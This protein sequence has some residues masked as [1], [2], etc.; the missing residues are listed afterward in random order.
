MV[1]RRSLIAT[2]PRA[3]AARSC[4][5]RRPRDGMAHDRARIFAERLADR[6]RERLVAEPFGNLAI[7]HRRAGRD[8][9][10]DRVDRRLKSGRSR[11]SI[12]TSLKSR[13]SPRNNATI[14]SIARCTSAGGAASFAAD[15]AATA[16]ARVALSSAS[17]NST[18]AI[19]AHSRRSRR[20]R[21]RCQT[22]VKSYCIMQRR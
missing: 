4:H 22:C 8:R 13:F 2:P 10:R 18:P 17:G 6:A 9:T 7:R 11:S 1:S 16:R 3:E 12:A 21:S 5:S 14:P 15:S 20:C 19:P